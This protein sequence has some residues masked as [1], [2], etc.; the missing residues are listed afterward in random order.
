MV[1]IQSSKAGCILLVGTLLFQYIFII[2]FYN[3]LLVGRNDPLMMFLTP[4]SPPSSNRH[5]LCQSTMKLFHNVTEVNLAIEANIH[6]H[7]RLGN[8]KSIMNYLNEYQ[9][10]TL[11]ALNVQ[12]LPKP[13][14]DATPASNVTS[15][16]DA[17]N[18]RGMIEY[19]QQYYATNDVKRGGYGQ[20]L[21]GTLSSNYS[22]KIIQD[23]MFG[24]RWINVIEP[25]T[26]ERYT[27]GTGPVGPQCSNML[28]FSPG[29]Y[30]EKKLCIPTSSP[31]SSR[32]NVDCNILSIGSNDQWGFE[33][34][35]T[36]QLPGCV[37][38]TFDC[39]LSDNTPKKKPMNDD[40]NFYPY[41]IGSSENQG[42]TLLPYDKLWDAVMTRQNDNKNTVSESRTKQQS[43]I[44][45]PPKLLKMDIEGYEF[46]VLH[47][48]LSSSDSSIWPE[49]IM[50]EVHWAT[51]MVGL[52]WMPRTLTAGE[53][54][55]FF[56]GL[57]NFGGY[58]VVD[59]KKING[60]DPCLE[61]LLVRV[62]C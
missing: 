56:G 50:L 58:M 53:I 16:K 19:L 3:H 6:F 61:V 37:T 22:P 51:R 35:V 5:N 29:T 10:S 43:A 2:M 34:E 33:M 27:A 23:A 24:G 45:S 62:L 26:N 21:P 4:P 46:D 31:S 14:E 28:T 41:C 17:D 20:P 9:Q 52:Q 49:Q 42:P 59:A 25:P 57:F 18:N 47:N 40:I 1:R 7:Q 36:Q 32:T 44:I 60:C 13:P 48:L 54:S 30:E 39:T 11:D 15:A 8:L 38:H 55:L 12:F